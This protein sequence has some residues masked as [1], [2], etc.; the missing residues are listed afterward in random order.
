MITFFVITGIF[1]W[2]VISLL[3]FISGMSLIICV[4]KESIYLII[5]KDN[6]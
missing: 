2:G 4:V 3:L 1:V 6:K 5:G